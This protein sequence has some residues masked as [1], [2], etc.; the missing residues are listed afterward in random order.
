M[1]AITTTYKFHTAVV[2]LPPTTHH[3]IIK[4]FNTPFNMENNMGHWQ[5]GT[6]ISLNSVDRAWP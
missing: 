5:P 6:K 3:R 1:T 2:L 4:G